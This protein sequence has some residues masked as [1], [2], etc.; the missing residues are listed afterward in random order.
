MLSHSAKL[1]EGI[2]IEW[3]QLHLLPQLADVAL[4]HTAACNCH[5][6]SRECGITTRSTKLRFTSAIDADPRTRNANAMYVL[7][8]AGS[9]GEP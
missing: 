9:W 3:Q 6:T 8:L 1:L 4:N 7:P 2:L 5:K